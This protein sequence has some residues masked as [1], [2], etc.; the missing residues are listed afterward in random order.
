[1]ECEVEK[2]PNDAVEV[3][4]RKAV[5]SYHLPP[6]PLVPPDEEEGPGYEHHT[7]KE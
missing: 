7:N 4:H 6:S 5:C 2:C 1:M 3:Y